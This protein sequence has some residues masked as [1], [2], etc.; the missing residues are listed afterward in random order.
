VTMDWAIFAVA[1][2][3]ILLLMSCLAWEPPEPPISIWNPPRRVR[4]TYFLIGAVLLVLAG[5]GVA[6]VLM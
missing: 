1:P 3:I 6:L 2:G 5:V 4:L